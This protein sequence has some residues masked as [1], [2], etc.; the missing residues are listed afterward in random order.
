MRLLRKFVPI[1]FAFALLHVGIGCCLFPNRPVLFPAP[2]GGTQCPCV[3]PIFARPG[4]PVV[5]PAAPIVAGPVYDAPFSHGPAIDPGCHGCAVNASPIHGSPAGQPQGYPSG[6]AGYG[7]I[8][9]VSGPVIQGPIA[10]SKPGPYGA[11]PVVN[12]DVP[13]AMPG[14][15]PHDSSLVPTVM[16]PKPG[17]LQNEAKKLVVAGK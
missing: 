11:T 4:V 14:G 2:C 6:H 9:V 16:P 1:A 5:A 13:K 15:F 7:G 10:V 3:T 12:V 17:E 8:P